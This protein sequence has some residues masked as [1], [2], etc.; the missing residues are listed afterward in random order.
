MQSNLAEQP[1]MRN[2][3]ECLTEIHIFFILLLICQLSQVTA[4]DTD[5][6]EHDGVCCPLCSA[7]NAVAKHCTV[8]TD[9]ECNPCP[10][11]EYI[12]HPNGF[13]KCLKCK[14]CKGGSGLQIEQ[15]CTSTLNTICKPKK[16]Y[17]CIRTNCAMAKIHS[18]CPAGHGVKEKGTQLNDTMCEM[19]PAGMFSRTK[20]ST[21]ACMNWTACDELNLQLFEP[22]SSD[23]DV[24]CAEA[25]N[26]LRI[27]IP[28]IAIAVIIFIL[29]GAIVFWR[30]PELRPLQAA[31]AAAVAAEEPGSRLASSPEDLKE[32][33]ISRGDKPSPAGTNINVNVSESISM[34]LRNNEQPECKVVEIGR[35][36]K[37]SPAGNHINV[38]DSESIS[39]P[40]RSNE[41]PECKVV[42][43]HQQSEPQ[44]NLPLFTWSLV[45]FIEEGNGFVEDGKRCIHSSSGRFFQDPRHKI[46]EDFSVFRP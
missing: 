13:E 1:T 32:L 21:E 39:M 6:Y 36:G 27:I 11:G 15:E 7:G 5:K 38:N 35:G 3:F 12:E 25:N 26:N 8:Q 42:E 20:S 4:C 18:T 44:P 43:E 29:I 24:K 33:R 34:L 37:P 16:G 30:Y 19:C 17:Y 14:T 31:A 41:Q 22:G 9:T 2:L 23:A 46:S 40:L 10:P 45:D 28:V